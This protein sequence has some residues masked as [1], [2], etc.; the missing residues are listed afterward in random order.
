MEERKHGEIEPP[1]FVHEL[2]QSL[3]EVHE[4]A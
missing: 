3:G 1:D 2:E 4:M